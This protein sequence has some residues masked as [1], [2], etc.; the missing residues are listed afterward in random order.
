MF[1]CD[2]SA[3][4]FILSLPQTHARLWVGLKRFG[5]IPNQ[6]PKHFYIVGVEPNLTADI[7]IW[8][9]LVIW[10]DELLPRDVVRCL[11]NI[12]DEK[13]V[14]LLCENGAYAKH[15]MPVFSHNVPRDSHVLRCSNSPFANDIADIS[16][17][18]IARLFAGVDG[19]V[20]GGGYN[21]VHE[22]LSY[23][24]LETTSFIRVGGDDQE[25]RIRLSSEWEHGRGSRSHELALHLYERLQGH[26]NA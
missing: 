23:A 3:D 22:A 7:T 14:Y 13:P 6:F 9:I 8:P 4:D 2:W 12:N 15:L 16:Y 21:S 26:S 10:H 25:R 18:P 1:I 20:L 17:Y 11:L 19:L 24:H 5:T